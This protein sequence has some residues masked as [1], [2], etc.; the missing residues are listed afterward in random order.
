MINQQMF[1]YIKQQSQQGVSREQIKNSLLAKGWSEND[2][3]EAFVAHSNNLA[4]FPQP[5]TSQQTQASLP[6]VITIL[7]QAWSLYKQRFGTFLGIMIIPTLISVGL[8]F[9]LASNR[10]FDFTLILLTIIFSL[11]MFISFV[12]GQIA[13]LYA[14]KDSQ[15]GI[16][17]VESY[18]RGAH[19][20]FSYFW[21]LLLTGFITA[22]GFFLLI[23]PGIIFMVWFSLAIFVLI[24]EDLKG[25]NAL[26]KSKEYVRGK[27]TAVFWR[28]LFI[29]VLSLIVSLVM[30]FILNFFKI[31]F[32]TEISN[33]IVGVFLTPLVVS[34]S[35]LVFSNLKTLKG[36]IVS[37]PTKNK[38]TFFIFIGI[39]WILITVLAVMALSSF[40]YARERGRRLIE[41]VQQSNTISSSIINEA[42]IIAERSDLEDEAM[43]KLIK[44]NVSL[45]YNQAVSWQPDAEWYSYRRMFT[46]PS[47]EPDKILTGVD[48]Y[49]FR[50]HNTA[51][52]YEVLFNRDSNNIAR[53]DL[54][55][56]RLV[57]VNFEESIFL[58][59]IKIGPK[60]AFEIGM[61]NP[62]MQKFKNENQEFYGSVY[63]AK[64]TFLK[65]GNKYYWFVSLVNGFI[66][67]IV[68]VDISTGE[69]LDY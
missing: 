11:F 61:L 41:S 15:E 6:G 18:K 27:W 40:K 38:K 25:M 31:P 26:L 55:K 22:G 37:I 45:G 30:G 57:G 65:S 62:K 23:V 44:D 17:F 67:E 10:S 4:P 59:D 50:S 56:D 43:I 49:Y 14:I 48:S 29:G 8:S 5:S 39:S 52:N 34:Y 7:S 16:G 13:L 33:F 51:D 32:S 28:F 12:W 64:T 35:F 24:V 46:I 54:N 42:R 60:K 21:V 53:V 19:K 68:L 2:I 9:V 20:I 63:T 66:N 58:E 1:D 47:N 69:I 36:E 3:N